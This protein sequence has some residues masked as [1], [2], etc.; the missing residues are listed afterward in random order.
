MKDRQYNGF[1]DASALPEE[2][3]QEQKLSPSPPSPPLRYGDGRGSLSN[4]PA[5]KRQRGRK[6]WTALG[7]PTELELDDPVVQ[8]VMNHHNYL[9]HDDQLD[10]QAVEDLKAG[11]VRTYDDLRANAKRV[12]A[13]LLREVPRGYAPPTTRRVMLDY[14]YGHLVVLHPVEWRHRAAALRWD[15]ARQAW[16]MVR[17]RRMA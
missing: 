8:P 16:F 17:E 15:H 5:A 3:Q 11:E 1:E 14:G 6:R 2:Q 10:Y 13:D 7:H 9:I 4:S 12:P